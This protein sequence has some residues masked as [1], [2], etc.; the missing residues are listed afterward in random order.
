MDKQYEEVKGYLES[1]KSIEIPGFT[2]ADL[3]QAIIVTIRESRRGEQPGHYAFPGVSAD[4][5]ADFATV[6]IL[7][8]FEEKTKS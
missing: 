3:R 5:L 6:N 1:V 8:T 2:V 4:E 7:R